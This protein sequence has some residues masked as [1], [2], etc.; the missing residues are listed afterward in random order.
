MQK[1][2]GKVDT[3]HHLISMTVMTIKINIPQNSKIHLK[4]S[5]CECP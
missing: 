3:V 5:Y 4:H 1:G 2:M